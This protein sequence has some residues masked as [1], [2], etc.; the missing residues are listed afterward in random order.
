MRLLR[1]RSTFLRMGHAGRAIKEMREAQKLS[2]R[3]LARLADVEP[4]YLSLV[5]RGEREP[6][7]R[8]LANVTDALGRHLSGAPEDEA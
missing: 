4:G 7:P 1:K 3:G 5:E 6:S 8:W 2:L